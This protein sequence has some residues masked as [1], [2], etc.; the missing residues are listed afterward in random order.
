MRI[1]VDLPDWCDERHIFIVAGIELAAY[2]LY[3][4]DVVQVKTERCSM[5]GQCCEEVPHNWFLGRTEE[6]S[7]V[8]L[9]KDSE[10][11]RPCRLGV[12][13]PWSCCTDLVRA[14]KIPEYD[15]CT[16]DYEARTLTGEA[17]K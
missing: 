13:R 8:H 16:V 9:Q 4:E 5:C 15:K 2:K 14:G 6:N 3:G 12:L 17:A 11:Y 7:C 1:V 10:E